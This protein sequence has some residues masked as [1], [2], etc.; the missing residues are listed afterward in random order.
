MTTETKVQHTPGPWKLSQQNGLCLFIVADNEAIA[1]VFRVESSGGFDATLFANARLIAAAPDMA[2]ALRAIIEG[3]LAAERMFS[4]CS[5]CRPSDEHRHEEG[6]PI[7]DAERLLSRW[8]RGAE[9]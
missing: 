5:I 2:K 4:P 7:L 3:A 9:G 8:E 1:E 6:C